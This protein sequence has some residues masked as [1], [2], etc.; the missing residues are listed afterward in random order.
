MGCRELG[1]RLRRAAASARASATTSLPPQRTPPAPQHLRSAL[2]R[3]T[4]AAAAPARPC[5]SASVSAPARTLQWAPAG[6]ARRCAAAAA[7]VE[8]DFRIGCARLLQELFEKLLQ[9]APGDCEPSSSS[10]AGAGG[11]GRGE[12]E[13]ALDLSFSKVPGCYAL[14]SELLEAIGD[15]ED[16][17]AF[18]G[19]EDWRRACA[20]ALSDLAGDVFEADGSELLPSLRAAVQ[21]LSPERVRRKARKRVLSG[22]SIDVPSLGLE[23]FPKQRIGGMSSRKLDLAG[24]HRFEPCLEGYSIVD[25]NLGGGAYARVF[26]VKNETTGSLQAMKRID[27]HKMMK[28]LQ[29]P[30]QDVVK[31]VEDEFRHL[32]LTDHEHIV[33]L[34]EFKQDSQFSYF[35]MEAANGGDL[36]KLVDRT[37]GRGKKYQRKAPASTSLTKL[38]EAY[39]AAVLDQALQALNYL[40]TDYRLHKDVKLENLMLRA[41][42]GPPHVLLVDLG[43]TETLPE[44]DGKL[45][46]GGTA[47]T[48]APEVIDT[49]LGRRPAGFDERSDIY[50]L[51]IVAHELLT[52]TAPY[53]VAYQ[54]GGCEGVVDYDATRR[55][56]GELGDPAAQLEAAGRSDGVT[57]LVR[58]MLA[59]D[60]ELRP[61]S[62]EC[63]ESTWLMAQRTRRLQR[64]ASSSS[65]HC[66]ENQDDAE[67]VQARRDLVS[68]DLR[69]FA[70]RSA[71]QKAAAYHLAANVPLGQ[72]RH[73]AE[74]LQQVREP[75]AN[76]ETSSQL[77]ALLKDA[78]GL[79]T[80]CATHVAESMHFGGRGPVDFD[81]F[82]EACV[83]LCSEREHMLR[84]RV[85]HVL[86]ATGDRGLS[87]D[88]VCTALAGAVHAEVK[89]AD[90]QE[91]LL[92]APGLPQFPAEAQL[93]IS[94]EVLRSHLQHSA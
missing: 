57:A 31:I 65:L 61:S 42:E 17:T 36:R 35:V 7:G 58:Q 11:V 24:L 1:F 79:D 87:V 69:H 47:A 8:E 41:S 6:Q 26:L 90:V 4:P 76:S 19:A 15:I 5:A 75:A 88:E 70:Q 18:V 62:S 50:S 55:R 94:A 84:D 38:S 29:L 44:E 92:A 46:P 80:C 93:P 16:Q 68:A 30:E 91:W 32:Q 51:G 21:K 86:D 39:V 85:L 73:V 82:V 59:T 48:M 9:A 54:G 60:P 23:T 14:V 78:T 77:A 89:A 72:L 12:L 53:E 33:K 25:A 10:S 66:S 28:R 56:I 43:V 13:V 3:C 27:R 81:E 83:T 64:S 52:G 67:E 40:H 74:G 49:Y 20:S 37:Y 22:R 45:V 71:M 63:L 2:L 34:L